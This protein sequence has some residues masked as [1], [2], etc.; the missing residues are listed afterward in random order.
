VERA[1]AADA[2]PNDHM[3]DGLIDLSVVSLLI[4]QNGTLMCGIQIPMSITSLQTARSTSSQYLCCGC[5]SYQNNHPLATD[6][7]FRVGPS[8]QQI[9]VHQLATKRRSTTG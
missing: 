2:Q 1:L 4:Y 7:L 8:K 5:I 3:I 9:E 6:T